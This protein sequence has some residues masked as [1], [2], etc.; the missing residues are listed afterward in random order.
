MESVSL[1][2]DWEVARRI[3]FAMACLANKFGLP[4]QSS[5][6]ILIECAMEQP[7]K[8]TPEEYNLIYMMRSEAPAMAQGSTE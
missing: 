4:L 6:E 7:E 3:A 5:P 1:S 8:V 2:E